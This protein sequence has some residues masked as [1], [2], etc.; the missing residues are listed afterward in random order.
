MF[1]PGGLK[2]QAQIPLKYRPF[3]LGKEALLRFP[4]NQTTQ[5][6]TPNSVY[7]K[8]HTFRLSRTDAEHLEHT[9]HST[10]LL[11]PAFTPLFVRNDHR[12]RMSKFTKQRN[13]KYHNPKCDAV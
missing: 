9:A 2:V 6:Q 7:H 13:K 1:K 12:L 8:R 11:L 10:Q 4:T 3:S 5:H